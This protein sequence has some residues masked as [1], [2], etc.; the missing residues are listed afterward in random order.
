MKNSIIVDSCNLPDLKS[1]HISNTKYSIPI[2]IKCIMLAGV[3]GDDEPAIAGVP[4]K[5]SNVFRPFQDDIENAC[6]N[7]LNLLLYHMP[8]L[9]IKNK[10]PTP[11]KYKINLHVVFY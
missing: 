2:D 7:T 11:F 10:T 8:Q 5:R 9:Y 4:K 3:G 1:S 6:N